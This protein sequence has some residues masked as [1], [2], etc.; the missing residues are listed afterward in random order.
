MERDAGWK[1]F[2]FRLFLCETRVKPSSSSLFRS[3]WVGL[4][5]RARVVTGGEA[6]AAGVDAEA[7]SQAVEVEVDARPASQAVEVGA[8]AEPQTVEEAGSAS[9][10]VG[11][12]AG[13]GSLAVN[14]DPEARA[15]SHAAGLT[16][17]TFSP[18]A[19]MSSWVRAALGRPGAGGAAGSPL[20]GLEWEE[21]SLEAADEVEER[22]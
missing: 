10:A 13:E 14:V 19:S 17:A 2:P 18:V 8:R 12:S 1:A 5:G 20:E 4:G 9:Q 7:A 6:V 21:W 15:P 11:G 3:C 22:R 16:E